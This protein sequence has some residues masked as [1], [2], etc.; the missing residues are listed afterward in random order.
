MLLKNLFKAFKMKRKEF[1][2]LLEFLDLKDPVTIDFSDFSDPGKAGKNYED[3][4]F[5]RQKSS[6]LHKDF[7]PFFTDKVMGRIAQLSHRQGFEEYLSMLLNRVLVYGMTAVV[8]VFL[9]LFFLHG[10]DGIGTVLGTDSSDELNF[11]SYLFYEF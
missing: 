7:S 9:T 6:G 1:K 2:R 8:I 3:L 11:I 4:L 10:Q 5:F